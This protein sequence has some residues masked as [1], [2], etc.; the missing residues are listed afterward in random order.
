MSQVGSTLPSVE[1]MLSMTF[2]EILGTESHVSQATIGRKRKKISDLCAVTYGK[3]S[4]RFHVISIIGSILGNRKSRKLYDEE[5]HTPFDHLFAPTTPTPAAN[6]QPSSARVSPTLT[7]SGLSSSSGTAPSV[8]PALPGVSA[9]EDGSAWTGEASAHPGADARP[10]PDPKVPTLD[11]LMTMGY[12]DILGVDPSAPLETIRRHFGILAKVTHPDKGG[13]PVVFRILRH[14]YE[15]L[16]DPEARRKY[17]QHGRAAFEEDFPRP[18]HTSV[19]SPMDVDADED[20][21]E[22]VNLRMAKKILELKAIRRLPLGSS[23]TWTFADAMDHVIRRSTRTCEPGLSWAATISARW[24]ESPRSREMGLKGRRQPGTSDSFSL[25]QVGIFAIGARLIRYIFRS[26]FGDR[27]Q[28]LDKSK[29]YWRYLLVLLDHKL[30]VV[31]DFPAVKFF[32]SN[33]DAIL[34]HELDCDDD[35]KKKLLMRIM[36]QGTLPAGLPDVFMELNREMRRFY[37]MVRQTFP[38]KIAIAKGWKKSRPEITVG[39]YLLMDVERCDLDK[40]CAAGGSCI[41]SPEADGVVV[42]G[43]TGSQLAAIFASTDHLVRKH[44]PQTFDAV[45]GFAKQRY[46]RL[47][48]DAKSKYPWKKLDEC[49]RC[50]LHDLKLGNNTDTV[51]VAKGI[52]GHTDFATIVAAAFEDRLVLDDKNLWIVQDSGIWKLYN[53]KA[54]H[55]LIRDFLHSK[56]APTRFRLSNGEIRVEQVG[57]CAKFMKAHGFLVSVTEEVKFL[58]RGAAPDF[59][60]TRGWLPFRCGTLYDFAENKITQCSAD[61]H[62]ARNLPFDYQEFD[63]VHEAEW[64]TL[65]AEI[66]EHWRGGGVIWI[67]EAVVQR[68]FAISSLAGPTWLQGCA[69]SVPKWNSWQSS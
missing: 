41:M 20:Y 65:T 52:A 1:A 10:T 39:S 2:Y 3:D 68:A 25:G 9:L 37:E 44:Y 43:A 32:V 29:A 61:M 56:F 36:F 15:V 62:L 51:D 55:G 59:D 24:H 38:E 30:H 27:M 23:T 57:A 16:S 33:I 54:L 66:I 69:P 34:E 53:E 4:D 13:D 12:Y 19:P 58:I 46:P 67:P 18:S 40:V 8:E 60:R 26:E 35:S 5:G 14:V 11:L 48:W 7:G 17:D 21:T 28:D 63:V 31:D 22:Y 42:F 50:V 49:L 64:K 45:I 6:A 47:N